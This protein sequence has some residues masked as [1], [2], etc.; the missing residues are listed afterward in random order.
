[1]GT[2]T[3]GIVGHRPLPIL[4]A[5]GPRGRR[6]R[7]VPSSAACIE[8]YYDGKQVGLLTRLKDMRE[9]VTALEPAVGREAG[10]K[11]GTLPFPEKTWLHDRR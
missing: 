7:Y 6:G 3:R 2:R 11:P 4:E 1:M 10:V 9:K 5:A 8:K